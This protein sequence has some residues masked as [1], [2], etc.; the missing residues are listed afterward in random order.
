VAVLPLNVIYSH[1]KLFFRKGVI[2]NI[3]RLICVNSTDGVAVTHGSLYLA[4]LFFSRVLMVQAEV[5]F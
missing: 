1:E 4:S 5:L 2:S 3:G